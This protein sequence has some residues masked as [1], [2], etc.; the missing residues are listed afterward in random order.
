MM[1]VKKISQ[2]KK[3]AVEAKD[4][5][6]NFRIYH[7]RNMSI[8]DTLVRLRRSIYEEFWALKGVSF[9]VE[10]GETFGIIGANG[11]GKSTLLKCIAGILAPAKGE[12]KVT[13]KISPLLEL[14]AGFHPEL[15]GRENV[16]VNGAILGMTRKQIDERFDDILAFS[17]L[18][19][20]IDTQVKFYSSGMYIRL[21]FAVAVYSDP[22]I[23]LIDEI[24]AVGDENFKKKSFDKMREFKEA[25]K[26]IIL[27]THDMA[28][29]SRFCDRLI[30]LKDGVVEHKGEP[31][32]VVRDYVNSALR[33]EKSSESGTKELVLN[34]VKIQND[35]GL[36][37]KR[38]SAGE[39]IEITADFKI[40]KPIKNPIFGIAIHD[41]QGNLSFG[42]NTKLINAS[43]GSVNGSGSISFRLN[44]LPMID[45]KF[46]VTIA[47]TSEN[48]ET[49]HWLDK[50]LSFEIENRNEN[51][52]VLYIPV[53]F[54]MSK[55]KQPTIDGEIIELEKHK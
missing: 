15:S 10:K 3:I 30:F 42:T 35:K 20:F 53:A 11:S 31:K 32:K 8:K 41:Q 23:L 43:T 40:K 50:F 14:G 12:I 33:D 4:V 7:H 25:G 37:S 9:S 54:N 24:M 52:G 44:N 46:Y 36:V 28:T 39:T 29:A 6:E 17:E 38:F 49:Y 34:N 2:N 13:G 21:G 26:T 47:A 51:E 5:W 1:R 48:D 55:N 27:V 22:D 45:G 16:Y 19:A 18:E